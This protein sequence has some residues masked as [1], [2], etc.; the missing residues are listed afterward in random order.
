MNNIALRRKKKSQG[1]SVREAVA[2]Y[3]KSLFQMKYTTPWIYTP[4]QIFKCLWDG[5]KSGPQN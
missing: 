4:G 5:D 2:V 1:E 3:Q